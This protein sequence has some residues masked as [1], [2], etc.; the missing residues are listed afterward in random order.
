MSFSQWCTRSESWLILINNNYE[1]QIKVQ[2]SVRMIMVICT[3]NPRAVLWLVSAH[4]LY[5]DQLQKLSVL[6][7]TV[8]CEN[9]HSHCCP[10]ATISWLPYMC[11]SN[12]WVA[13]ILAHWT[14]DENCHCR[15]KWSTDKNWHCKWKWIIK[16][17]RKL[18]LR[19]EMKKNCSEHSNETCS[20]H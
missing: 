20:D 16:C 4:E 2:T 12:S 9:V 18:E 15:L 7:L 6:L 1:I 13:K 11:G 8:V 3:R 5:T 19:V 10:S 17:W 14:A